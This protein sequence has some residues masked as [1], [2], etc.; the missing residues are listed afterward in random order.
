LRKELAEMTASQAA[1]PSGEHK[2]MLLD[3]SASSSEDD[4]EE[5]MTMASHNGTGATNRA[6]KKDE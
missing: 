3:G 5:V 2:S 4:S 6:F 1:T